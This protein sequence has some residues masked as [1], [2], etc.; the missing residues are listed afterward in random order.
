MGMLRGEQNLDRVLCASRE[1]PAHRE[2]EFER[3]GLNLIGP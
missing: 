2:G 3:M 1:Q